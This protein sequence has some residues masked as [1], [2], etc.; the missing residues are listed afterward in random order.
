MSCDA[1]AAFAAYQHI[2]SIFRDWGEME[3]SFCC[4]PTSAKSKLNNDVHIT[5]EN[6]ICHKKTIQDLGRF[7]VHL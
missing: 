4:M 2:S 1:I 6:P 7:A 5:C 3:H